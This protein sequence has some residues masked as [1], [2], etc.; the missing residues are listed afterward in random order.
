[1]PPALQ[2]LYIQIYVY[3]TS[4]VMEV[5]WDHPIGALELPN[6]ELFQ[7]YPFLYGENYGHFLLKYY[8]S[9]FF[10][11]NIKFAIVCVVKWYL[12]VTDIR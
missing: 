12:C 3:F 6:F 10:G 11:D 2:T 7:K 5:F 8:K 1:M 9:F 4:H